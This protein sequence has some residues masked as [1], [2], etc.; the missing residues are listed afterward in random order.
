MDI[1]FD[2]PS[3]FNA[4]EHFDCVPASMKNG[5]KLDKHPCGYYFQNISIADNISAIPYDIAEMLEYQKIDFLSF[6]ML[7]KLTN[8][9]L[10]LFRKK[11]PDWTLLQNPEI[12][13]K[14]IHLGTLNSEGKLKHIDTVQYIKPLNLEE[15]ADVLALIRPSNTCFIEQYPIN[16]SYVR[17]QIYKEKADS[18]VFKR[19]HAFSYA[20]NIGVQINLLV[21]KKIFN[22]NDF[23]IY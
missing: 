13:G 17:E 6:H 9:E 18:Y 4:L 21:S 5:D 2:L 8:E 23:L 19:S 11:E 15:V 12:L 14:V 7:D 20:Q 22:D 10:Q 16:K 1:D 3:Y